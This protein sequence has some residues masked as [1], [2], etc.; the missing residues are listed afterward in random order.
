MG[1][2]RVCLDFGRKKDPDERQA[3][4]GS[5]MSPEYEVKLADRGYT[6]EVRRL[7][8]GGLLIVKLGSQSF[9]LKPMLGQS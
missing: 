9:T 7:D 2:G 5:M 4:G 1:T 8:E 3:T 6:V